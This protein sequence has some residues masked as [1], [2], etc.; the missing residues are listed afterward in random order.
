MLLVFRVYVFIWD[1][2][3]FGTARKWKTTTVLLVY[4]IFFPL[5]FGCFVFFAFISCSWINRRVFINR[6][7]PYNQSLCSH[8]SISF[9]CSF[10]FCCCCLCRIEIRLSCE[11]TETF[12]FMSDTAQAIICQKIGNLFSFAIV[13]V[14]CC[15]FFCCWC[16][17][18]CCFCYFS[19]STRLSFYL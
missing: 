3:Y 15:S 4:F 17:C 19:C 14:L 7:F 13:W 9:A 2:C 8:F 1:E 10:R 6:I 16:C 12:R 5:L 18:C 11:W